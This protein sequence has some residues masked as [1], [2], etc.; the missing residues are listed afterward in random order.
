MKLLCADQTSGVLRWPVTRT[1]APGNI[2]TRVVIGMGTPAQSVSPTT[3]T[4]TTTTTAA[5]AVVVA[6][7]SPGAS[8]A[9]TTS[10]TSTTI[11]PTSCDRTVG[12]FGGTGNDQALSI[13]ADGAGNIYTT[14]LFSGTVDFDPG[15][16]INNLISSGGNDVFVSKLDSSG[17]FVW[18]R[19]FGGIGSDSGLAIAVDSSG[20]V[21]SIGNFV[22]TAD[23]DP[24]SGTTSNLIS[25]GSGDV[26]VSKLDSS[27]AFVW[28]KQFGGTLDDQG[29]GIAVDSSA[30][31]YTTGYFYGTADFDPASGSSSNL[32]SAGN[33]NAFV[34]KL[35]SSGAFV[36]AK[37]L[38]GTSGG[39]AEE[40]ALDG[41]GNVYTTG[42]FQGT[43]DFDPASGTTSNLTSAGSLDVFVSK[44]DSSGAFVWAV[45]FGS[46]GSDWGFGI[47]LD[48]SSNVHTT[49]YFSGTVDFDPGAGTC[50]LIS[51]G[52]TDAFVSNLNSAGG[53]IS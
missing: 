33:D 2:P 47:V 28:A 1:C 53:R 46:T 15:S 45:R 42:Y 26:F 43:F 25:A 49:G 35:D 41:S 14:G 12:A 48:G 23:F 37:R 21:H 51:A 38:G 27:G 7:P 52:S 34:S 24:A 30:N 13:T 17:S 50:E 4:T 16:G 3:S 31:V 9:T 32:I 11:A 19:Q 40:I 39:Y 18:A 8:G 44:L 29:T 6:A 36:W 20:N 10:S 5:P 22:G